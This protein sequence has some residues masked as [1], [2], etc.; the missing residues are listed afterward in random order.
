[1]HETLPDNCYL[2]EKQLVKPLH[3]LKNNTILLKKY[4]DIFAEKKEAGIMESF[5]STSISGDCHYIAHHPVFKNKKLV[6]WGYILM[7]W[8]KG[9]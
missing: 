7:L 8:C 9:P 1:M 2:C 5:E 4:G 6:S 3:N